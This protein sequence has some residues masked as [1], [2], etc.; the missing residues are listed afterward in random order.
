MKRALRGDREAFAQLVGECEIKLFR[1]ALAITG[2]RAD[3]EDAW[4]NSVLN[5]FR[6][7]QSL[8]EPRYFQT[9][10]TRI[11]LNECK[12]VLR[13]RAKQSETVAPGIA[14]SPEIGTDR[15]DI[16]AALAELS[17]EQREVIV[18]RFWMGKTLAEIAE[19]TAVPEGTAKT[20]LY[21]AL[22][23]LRVKLEEVL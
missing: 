6:S 2:N 8:R 16:E 18:L 20:R 3:A 14:H 11:L 21:Q 23:K 7:I 10:L 13:V 4:Q 15:L 1:T 5:A 9:W 17:H 19:L 12:H 22:R